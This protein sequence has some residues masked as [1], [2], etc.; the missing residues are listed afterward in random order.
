MTEKASLENRGFIMLIEAEASQRDLITLV[1][2]RAGFNVVSAG[3]REKAL[4]LVKTKAPDMVLVD[5]LLPQMN[6]LQLLE[7]LRTHGL[8]AAIPV[9]VFSALGFHEVVCQAIRAGA[10][11]F[12]VKPI[13][14]D[15]MLSRIER[16]F[17]EKNR[18]L[19]AGR[20]NH[21]RYPTCR[22]LRIS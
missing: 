16:I 22:G 14:V 2:E 9:I 11:E 21:R 1:L 5:L 10:K 18:H 15:L 4:E 3:S 12:L 8:P 20:S 17:L 7:E 6:G 19:E 13:D